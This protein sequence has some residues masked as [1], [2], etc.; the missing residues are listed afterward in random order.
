MRTFY[1]PKLGQA[2]DEFVFREFALGGG[3]KLPCEDENEPRVWTETEVVQE[4]HHAVNG[5]LLGLV[6]I[7]VL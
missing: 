1:V 5:Y 3:F 7:A 2:V 6:R 4:P